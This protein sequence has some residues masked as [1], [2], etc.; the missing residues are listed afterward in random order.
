MSSVCVASLILYYYYLGIYMGTII[1]RAHGLMAKFQCVLNPSAVS[2][3][4]PKAMRGDGGASE[5]KERRRRTTTR[6]LDGRRRGGSGSGGATSDFVVPSC[7]AAVRAYR[8]HVSPL[9]ALFLVASLR[10]KK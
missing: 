5:R 10:R 4:A 6:S 2:L 3:C 1:R 7:G 9:S 8:T